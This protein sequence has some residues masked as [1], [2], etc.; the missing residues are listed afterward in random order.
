MPTKISAE[1][2]YKPA[3]KWWRKL[4]RALLIVLIPSAVMMLQSWE[5]DNELKAT[6]LILI[7]NT[8]LVAIVKA[9]GMFMSNGEEY[10]KVEEE[11]EG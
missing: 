7:I 4:E 2:I 11:K 5:F 6:R 9:V 3:P 1:S 8:G 10:V